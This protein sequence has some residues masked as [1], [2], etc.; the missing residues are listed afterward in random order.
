[1]P[2]PLPTT[3]S[4]ALVSNTFTPASL[5]GLALWLR[6]DTG[7]YSGN[8]ASFTAASTQFLSIADNA[9]LSMGAGVS[10]TMAGWVWFNGLGTVQSIGG[11]S[12]TTIALLALLGE[13][14]LYKDATDKI[15]FYVCDGSTAVTTQSAGTV[16]SGA[17]HFVVGRR[18]GVN[19]S[20][21]VDANAFVNT[22]S[23]VAAQDSTGAFVLGGTDS[24]GTTPLDGRMDAVGVWKRALTNTEV[25]QIYNGGVG[26]RY[27]Q[28]DVGLRTTLT[29]WWDL[30]EPTGNRLDGVGANTLASNNSVSIADGIA[31]SAAVDG[32]AVRQ[33]SGQINMTQ[34]TATLRPL[35]KTAIIGGRSVLR[36]DGTDDFM[37]A[38]IP[39]LAAQTVGR[40]VQKRSA[41]AAAIQSALSWG[42]IT[43]TLETTST[44]DAAAYL[45]STNQAAGQSFITGSVAANANIVALIFTSLAALSAYVNSAA[46]AAALDPSDGYASATS[47]IL[48]AAASATQ[49]GDYDIAEVVLFSRALN[50]TER[51]QLN[52]YGSAKYSIAVT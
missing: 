7:V 52:L 18:D 21:R 38:T 46:A 19:I 13:Y 31:L 4:R 39:A 32:D 17:W 2:A 14:V 35:Y 34:A 11:K 6:A 28:L 51:R 47:L 30:E 5:P 24:L 22:A 9:S 12:V 23:A 36:F 44:L 10:F 29:S 48:G 16:S 49:P 50:I 1:M 37:T 20:L 40:V 33:W 15:N 45:W 8:A 42:A 27:Q 41:P 43:S 3:T 25:D 26:L